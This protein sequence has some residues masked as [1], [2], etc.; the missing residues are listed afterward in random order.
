MV[1]DLTKIGRPFAKS[2]V[3]RMLK[4]LLSEQLKAL[5]KRVEAEER[6]ARNFEKGGYTDPVYLLETGIN[7]GLRQ[8]L[9]LINEVI[10]RK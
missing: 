2:E 5:G 9:S 4:T 7:E 6:P 8:A 1:C 10:E 3:R